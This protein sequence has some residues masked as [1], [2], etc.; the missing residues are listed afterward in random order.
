VLSQSVEGFIHESKE[1]EEWWTGEELR[2]SD[3]RSGALRALIVCNLYSALCNLQPASRD[4]QLQWRSAAPVNFSSGRFKTLHPPSFYMISTC[5]FHSCVKTQCC[6]FLLACGTFGVCKLQL[7][8]VVSTP[9]AICL[10][11]LLV[12]LLIP[13]FVVFVFSH[14]ASWRPCWLACSL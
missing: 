10:F 3:L 9:L 5:I 6:L 7:E 2:L 4:S 12:H 13:K 1:W 8:S 14:L 11:W